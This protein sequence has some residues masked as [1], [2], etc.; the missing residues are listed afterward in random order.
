[1]YVRLVKRGSKLRLVGAA[2]FLLAAVLGAGA[3]S[4]SAAFQ[5]HNGRIAYST[6]F[7]IFSVTPS[8]K[9]LRAL[10]PKGPGLRT[11]PAY[12]PNGKLIV[13]ARSK[14]KSF[15]DQCGF[16][17]LWTMAANGSHP[18]QLTSTPDIFERGPAWSPDGKQIVFSEASTSTD[19]GLWVMNADG[20][21]LRQLTPEGY[22]P[23][24][25]P[26]GKTIAYLVVGGTNDNPTANIYDIPA[27][28]G[29]PTNLTPGAT[30]AS[31]PDWSPG[32]R[33][34]VFSLNC[35]LAVMKADGSNEHVITHPPVTHPAGG[36]C[37]GGP[38]WSPDGRWIVF[39]RDNGN[40]DGSA[41]NIV[42]PDGKDRHRTT[43]SGSGPTWQRR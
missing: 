8:G 39:E 10:T 19:L 36:V 13:Y 20:S 24:W 15:Q 38:A 5:V 6:G 3:K 2:G 29:D 37:D 26:D 28:G 42:H 35:H 25:S 27:A 33:R 30:S 22:T 43:R 34:I 23:A 4:S 9:G 12:S 7:Q 14:C 1:L 21:G 31:D 18:H 16:Q 17:D 11:A 40:T 41:L 32:G